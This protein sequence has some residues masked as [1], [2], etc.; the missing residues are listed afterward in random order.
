MTSTGKVG[1]AF[2]LMKVAG[3]SLARRQQQSDAD[4]DLRHG[5]CAN[6]KTSTPTSSRSRKR[7]GDHRKLGRELNL[8]HFQEEGPGVVF[9]H[10]KGW[11]IFQ[12]LI[13]YM[14]RRLSGDYSEVNAPQILDKSLW[15]TPAI[16]T[17]IA[18]TC[19]P[20]NRR[21][22]GRGQALVCAKADELSG[23]CADLQAR[24]EELSRPAVALAEF[25]VVHRYE[26]SGAMH[27]LMRVRASPRTTR[28]C[29]APSSSSPTSAS[30]S[31]I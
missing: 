29:S 21:R 18:R 7:E 6:R 27:G 22:R 24:P 4:A 15:E 23:P 1:N 19:S 16:G 5:V 17:G 3:A 20:R 31:T 26:P 28:M 2:K 11:S 9:W 30:R 12:A 13:S 10:A 25:G 14:R 8:F